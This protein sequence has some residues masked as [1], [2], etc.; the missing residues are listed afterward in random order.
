MDKEEEFFNSYFKNNIGDFKNYSTNLNK[1]KYYWSVCKKHMTSFMKGRQYPF[2]YSKL[3]NLLNKELSNQ[4]V[5]HNAQLS[6]TT[7]PNEA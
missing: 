7:K 2:Y 5:D 1:S 4:V 3:E 6:D